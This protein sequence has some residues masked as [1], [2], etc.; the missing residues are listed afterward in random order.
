MARLLS[1]TPLVLLVDP[2]TTTVAQGCGRLIRDPENEVNV[3]PGSLWE[4]AIKPS[5]GRLVLDLA[6]LERTIPPRG[7]R[8][9]PIRNQHL[10]AGGRTGNSPLH[11]DPLIPLAGGQMPQRTAGGCSTAD[12]QLAPTDRLVTVFDPDDPWL[13]SGEPPGCLP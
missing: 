13:R 10:L 1:D 12:R 9:L 6:K 2:Q 5:V 4:L 8:W 3:Q 7:F 11:C